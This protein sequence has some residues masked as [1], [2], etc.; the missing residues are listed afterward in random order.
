[1]SQTNENS[2][3]NRQLSKKGLRFSGAEFHLNTGIGSQNISIA[4]PP[5]SLNVTNTVTQQETINSTIKT[6]VEAPKVE[7]PVIEEVLP[8]KPKLQFKK[9]QDFGF[10]PTTSEPFKPT[11]SEPFKPTTSEPFKPTTSEPF[12]PTTSAPFNPTESGFSQRPAPISTTNSDVNPNTSSPQK[13]LGTGNTVNESNNLNANNTNNTMENQN[14]VQSTNNLNDYNNNIQNAQQQQMLQQQAMYNY[15][16][17]QQ[18]GQSLQMQLMNPAYNDM[19]KNMIKQKMNEIQVQMVQCINIVQAKNQM[20]QN[21]TQENNMTEESQA[22]NKINQ[23]ANNPYSQGN[24]GMGL[25]NQFLMQPQQVMTANI[26]QQNLGNNEQFN[27]KGLNI[28]SYQDKRKRSSPL[29]KT[30]KKSNTEVREKGEAFPELPSATQKENKEDITQA[31]NEENKNEEVQQSNEPAKKKLNLNAKMWNDSSIQ[32]TEAAENNDGNQES[33]KGKLQQT[34]QNNN[35][36][37]TGKLQS[38]VLKNTFIQSKETTKDT[39][40]TNQVVEQAVQQEA[41]KKRPEIRVMG[42]ANEEQE[43]PDNNHKDSNAVEEVSKSEGLPEEEEEESEESSEHLDETD[44]PPI[45]KYTLSMIMDF[46][47]KECNQKLNRK[48]DKSLR[49]QIIEKK[50]NTFAKHKS[51]GGGH[52]NNPNHVSKYGPGSQGDNNYHMQKGGNYDKNKKY[53]KKEYWNNK[54]KENAKETI[55]RMVYT[56]AEQKRIDEIADNMGSFAKAFENIDERSKNLREIK[57]NLFAITAE[58]YEEI[59]DCLRKFCEERDIVPE[60]IK[61]VIERAWTQPQFTKVYANLC[62]DLGSYQYEWTKIPKTHE[63]EP[64]KFESKLFKNMVI[65]LI[66]KEFFGGFKAFK[67]YIIGVESDTTLSYED[68]FEKYN[69]KKGKLMGNIGFIAELHLLKYLPIKVMK[70]ITYNLVFYFTKHLIE[71][72]TTTV[73]FPIEEEYLEALIKLF[74]YSGKKIEERELKD[75]MNNEAYAIERKTLINDFVEKLDEAVQTSTWDEKILG[76]VDSAKKDINCLYLCFEFLERCLSYKI[77]TRL[78]SLIENLFDKRADK[79]NETIFQ[80]KGPKKLAELEEELLKK[81]AKKEEENNNYHHGGGGDHYHR[82]NNYNNNDVEYER[83][84]KGHRQDRKHDGRDRRP[85]YQDNKFTKNHSDNT[86]TDNQGQFG[87]KEKKSSDYFQTENFRRGFKNSNDQG[88]ALGGSR[89]FKEASKNSYGSDLTG[90]KSDVLPSIKESGNSFDK[91]KVTADL[92]KFFKDNKTCEEVQTYTDYFSGCEADWTCAGNNCGNE[93]FKIY[94]ETYHD[95]H[96]N[97]ALTRAKLI[98]ELYSTFSQNHV[99]DDIISPFSQFTYECSTEG[100]FGDIPHQPDSLATMML[101]ILTK[102]NWKLSDFVWSWHDDPMF[103]EENAY[104]YKSILKSL[105]ELLIA[106]GHT[107]L[108]ASVDSEHKNL[109]PPTA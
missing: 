93:F 25:Q 23:M 8:K 77:S 22:Q 44:K 106:Q 81:N 71:S 70:F 45:M 28:N 94:L 90:N 105:K 43:S 9:N 6:P 103:A 97:A 54:N 2:L 91:A 78:K 104:C 76:I 5:T 52:H 30:S 99:K 80:T 62:Y 107:E 41:I 36:D 48:L 73:Q 72:S 39:S 55:T 66:R 95:C 47:N 21:P 84:D 51:H 15:Q 102:L 60:L 38:S 101:V 42:V 65:E 59:R 82:K 57:L 12:K 7:E 18:Q 10:K 61:I 14:N 50:S 13:E 56:E 53:N 96:K 4:N 83:A 108:A 46:M 40:E 87:F 68:K 75:D 89:L 109:E 86:N 64:Q 24:Q 49:S 58:N 98:S 63:S 1:M 92:K 35:S 88:D 67:N 79:W 85:R 26:P 3:K 69:K 37:S 31:F 100:L 11:T 20:V 27:K 32:K 17:L 16:M 29:R 19:Q 74:E 33:E 34:A